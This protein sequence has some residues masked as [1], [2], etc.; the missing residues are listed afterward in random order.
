M[1]TPCRHRVHTRRRRIAALRLR[2]SDGVVTDPSD[3][4]AIVADDGVPFDVTALSNE[5]RSCRTR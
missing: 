4:E 2:E 5:I 3:K 1:L